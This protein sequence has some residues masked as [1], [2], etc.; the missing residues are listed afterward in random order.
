[1]AGKTRGGSRKPPKV[2]VEGYHR[3]GNDVGNYTRHKPS[4]PKPTS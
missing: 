4:K 3:R 2:R 1:M